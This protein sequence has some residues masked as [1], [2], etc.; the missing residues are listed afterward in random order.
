MLVIDNIVVMPEVLEAYFCCDLN[1]CKG[2]CCVEGDGGAPLETAE[3][4]QL[5]TI[6][7]TVAPTLTEDGRQAITEQGHYIRGWDGGWE[8]PLVQGRECAYVV[9][10]EVGI[11]KCGIELQWAEGKI[12]FRKPISCQLYPIRVEDKGS[13]KVL[14][15]HRWKICKGGCTLGQQE[16]LPLYKF[17]KEPL[18]RAFGKPFYNALEHLAPKAKGKKK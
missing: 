17:L 11:A 16:K 13:M 5:E 3:L 7:P 18:I 6:Y 12:A 2:A 15:Y 10:D 14:H 1:A 9:F 8:T 4:A